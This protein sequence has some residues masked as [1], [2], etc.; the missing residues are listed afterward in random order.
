MS[1]NIPWR[2]T[3]NIGRKVTFIVLDNRIAPPGCLHLTLKGSCRNWQGLLRA[4]ADLNSLCHISS[5]EPS[6]AAAFHLSSLKLQRIDSR[7]T[8]ILNNKPQNRN[9]KGECFLLFIHFMN[10]AYIVGKNLKQMLIIS[11]CNFWV[12]AGKCQGVFCWFFKRI[13]SSPCCRSFLLPN[14]EV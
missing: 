12:P 3:F 5:S 14:K 11:V 10:T 2:E 9:T 6:S 8:G 13:Y 4:A 1:N 7:V